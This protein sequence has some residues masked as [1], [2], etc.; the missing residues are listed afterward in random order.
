MEPGGQDEMPLQ[1][2][3]GGAE[4]GEH[5]LVRHARSLPAPARERNRLREA[6]EIRCLAAS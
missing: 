1:Q 3:L 2:G 5:F 6:A 4:F